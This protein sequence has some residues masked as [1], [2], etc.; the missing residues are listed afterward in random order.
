MFV[1]SERTSVMK[2]VGLNNHQVEQSQRKYGT[3]TSPPVRRKTAWQF[4]MEMFHDKINLILLGMMILFFV[5]A[6]FGFGGYIEPIGVGVVLICVGA[7]GTITKLRAQK[8]A[9]DLKNLQTKRLNS[10]RVSEF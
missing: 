4:F 2:F 8:Y 5:F 1:D 9:F 10:P 7:I 6:V 3:N